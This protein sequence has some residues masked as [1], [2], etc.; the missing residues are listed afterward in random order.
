MS[1]LSM[2]GFGKG[3]AAD[4]AFAVTCEIK[5]VNNR[6]KDFR[7]KMSSI[8]NSIE[9]DLKKS[10]GEKFKRGSFEIS[11]N[12]RKGENQS[13]FTDIDDNKVLDYLDKI[14]ALAKSEGV[15]VN[16]QPTEFLRG[17]FYKDQELG[18][19]LELISLVKKSFELALISL[20][21]SRGGEGQ[22]L[23]AV[24]GK[25]KEVFRENYSKILSLS[26]EFQKNVEE[27]LRKKFEDIKIELD[28][29]EPRFMQEVVYYLEKIDVDEEINRIEVHLQKL[30]TLIS[31]GGEMGR[32]LDFLVQELNRETNTI[33]SKSSLTEISECVVN[34]KVQLEKIREQGLNIE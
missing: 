16:I 17:E 12:F 27:K 9:L 5:S 10:L 15:Q 30:E 6:Y 34:M 2:T 20:E 13:K 28:V 31:S 26:K 21:E 25:H 23:I 29:E 14:K 33:G 18:K 8:F 22:K 4:S 3:E 7:F 19:N 24:L 11:I 1:V 32:Q